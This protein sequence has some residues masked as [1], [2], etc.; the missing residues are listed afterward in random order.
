MHP[1]LL[2]PDVVDCIFAFIKADRQISDRTFAALARTC[3]TLSEV[4][5]DAL[6]SEL[7]SLYPLISCVYDTNMKWCDVACFKPISHVAPHTKPVVG[8]R[9]AEANNHAGLDLSVFDKYAYR[10]R[11]LELTRSGYFQEGWRPA[12]RGAPAS[13]HLGAFL[14][15]QVATPLLPNLNHLVCNDRL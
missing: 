14:L 3:S 13:D 12:A 1:A 7:R 6:W 15:L 9:T 4:S 8:Q 2:V 11:K 5:L 10:V